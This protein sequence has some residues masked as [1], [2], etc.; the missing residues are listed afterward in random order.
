[1]AYYF[2]LAVTIVIVAGTTGTL[3]RRGTVPLD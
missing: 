1:M 2:G 3:M